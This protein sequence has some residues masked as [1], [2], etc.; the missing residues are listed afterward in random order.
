M[1]GGSGGGGREGREVFEG[2]VDNIVGAD[3]PA[4]EGNFERVEAFV[5]CGGYVGRVVVL[6][7]KGE[8]S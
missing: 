8:M 6:K 5:G 4:R 2:S 1:T 7:K 3:I